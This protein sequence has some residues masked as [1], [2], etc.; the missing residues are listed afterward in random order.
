M[1]KKINIKI[2]CKITKFEKDIKKV[3]ECIRSFKVNLFFN[4]KQ[5][6][7]LKI[8]MLSCRRVYDKCVELYTHYKNN[9][10]EKIGDD[11]YFPLEYTKLKKIIFNKVFGKNKKN[12]PF[13]ILSYEVKTFIENWKSSMKIHHNDESKFEMRPKDIRKYQTITIP[14]KSIVNGQIFASRLKLGKQ[15][16]NEEILKNIKFACDAKLTYDKIFNRFT[17]YAP[18]YKLI[19][20]CRIIGETPTNKRKPIIALDPGINVFMSYFSLDEAGNIGTDTKQFILHNHHK[21]KKYQKI[22]SRANIDI[23][24][25]INIKCNK[26]IRKSSIK[27][28]NRLY[29]KIKGHV[30]ELHKRTANFLVKKYDTVLIPEFK[31]KEILK[32]MT[33]IS[34][35]KDSSNY[36]KQYYSM[37]MAIAGI[38]RRKITDEEKEKL[39]KE[40]CQK[41]LNLA[42]YALLKRTL[43]EI[44]D[45]E[46]LTYEEKQIKR[47]Q[48]YKDFYSL[49]NMGKSKEEIKKEM[50]ESKKKRRINENN[51]FVLGMLSHYSFRQY[52]LAKA[53]E[54]DCLIKIVTEEFTSKA[55]TKCSKLSNKYSEERIKECTNPDCGYKIHRDLNGAR[56]ILLKNI[57]K[58]INRQKSIASTSHAYV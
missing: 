42:H 34:T 26:K 55:C 13:D 51:K 8:W 29:R 9:E 54:Y 37:R 48:A 25:G 10:P 21:I 19:K 50:K 11:K 32:K 56:N 16:Q 28:I 35:I 22:L 53:Q 3:D 17:I 4:K 5:Q 30:N 18:Q 20:S 23:K 33:N 57:G 14:C 58:E 49:E 6:K 43:K 47:R 7:I 40:I 44:H 31:T 52:L 36:K 46:I 24:N 39:I 1:I 12:C 41:N 2:N 38:R 15:P 27:S 45:D